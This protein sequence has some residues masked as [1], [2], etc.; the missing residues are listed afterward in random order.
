MHLIKFL[1][2]YLSN[3]SFYV[4]L[5]GTT[6]PVTFAPAG[7]PQGSILGSTL[8]SIFIND[9]PRHSNNNIAL[10]AA[11]TAVFSTSRDV[12]LLRR[13]LE[14]HID[15]ILDHFG[16]W[17]I[18]I[19]AEKT[20]YTVFSKRRVP[21]DLTIAIDGQHI[22]EK[23]TC[24]YLGLQMDRGLT[25]TRHIQHIRARGLATIGR[26]YHLL[27]S[28]SPIPEHVKHHIFKTAIRTTL[29]YASPIWSFTASHNHDTLEACQMK[30]LS[31]FPS[32][33]YEQTHS[34]ESP[35]AHSSGND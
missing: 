5:N 13:R 27:N 11:D 2:S 23:K 22:P 18:Q 19:N 34:K 33:Y 26:V 32:G 28:H 29:L 16:T 35:N 7:V 30:A 1:R 4:D 31:V 20:Q 25:F 10:F 9:I 24:T 14:N 17:R 21:P 8:F 12:T 3:R 6:S 15:A